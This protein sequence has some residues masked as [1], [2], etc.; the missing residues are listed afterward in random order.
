MG[1][2]SFRVIYANNLYRRCL[3][4]CSGCCRRS[5]DCP[6][7]ASLAARDAAIVPAK[8]ERH[9]VDGWATC[10]KPCHPGSVRLRF[11][12]LSTR[13]V[14]EQS[15]TCLTLV[16]GWVLAFRAGAR[17]GGFRKGKNAVSNFDLRDS[18]SLVLGRCRNGNVTFWPPGAKWIAC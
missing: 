1:C 5:S 3:T 11:A 14:P 4:G 18:D 13:G 10:N 9:I 12:R 8:V 17:F 16:T 2:L 7:L 6:R 15:Q